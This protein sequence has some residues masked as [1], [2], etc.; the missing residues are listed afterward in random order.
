MLFI[1]PH[2]GNWE[3]GGLLLAEMGIKLTVLTQAEPE[4]A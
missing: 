1:T 3:H 4:A 2:L